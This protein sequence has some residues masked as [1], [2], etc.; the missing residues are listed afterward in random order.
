M[1]LTLGVSVAL[2]VGVVQA[3]NHGSAVAAGIEPV[4]NKGSG[5][6]NMQKTR[7]RRSETNTS[8]TF[9]YSGSRLSGARVDPLLE[10]RLSRSR[11]S[12]VP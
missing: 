10:N 12:G 11:G 6:A 1:E 2:D 9:E 5:T 8:I 7:G 3:E 4:K